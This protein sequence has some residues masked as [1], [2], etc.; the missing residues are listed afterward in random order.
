MQMSA[1]FVFLYIFVKGSVHS[2]VVSTGKPTVF[3]FHFLTPVMC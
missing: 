1:T 2:F 3:L